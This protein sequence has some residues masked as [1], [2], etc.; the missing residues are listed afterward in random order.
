M[1]AGMA[2]EPI[3]AAITINTEN[4]RRSITLE[5]DTF[6]IAHQAF[7]TI[8]VSGADLTTFVLVKG[9]TSGAI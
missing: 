9:L 3:S 7:I 4:F 2:I 6:G 1:V 5:A 8:A